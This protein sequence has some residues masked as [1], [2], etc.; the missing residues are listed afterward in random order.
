MRGPAFFVAC[1]SGQKGDRAEVW[2]RLRIEGLAPHR[3]D[4]RTL[5]RM[6]PLH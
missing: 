6:Q 5:A 3:A 2:R 1:L 4:A